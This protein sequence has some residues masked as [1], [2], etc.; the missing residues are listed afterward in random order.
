MLDEP[1]FSPLGKKKPCEIVKMQKI[2]SIICE[3]R[4]Y[5]LPLHAEI[6]EAT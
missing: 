3:F 4:F 1:D 5:Y 6:E 2:D